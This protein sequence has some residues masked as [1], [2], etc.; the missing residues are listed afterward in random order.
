ML[1]VETV[2]RIRR[3]FH[4]KKKPIKAIARELGVSRNTIRKVLR[5]EET[6]FSYARDRQPMP[7]LARFRSELDALLAANAGKPAREKLTLIRIYEALKERGYEGGYDAV[8]RYG[9]NW[10]R[11]HST[12]LADAYV[13]LSFAPGEAFQFD[14][15]PRGRR[16]RRRH[17]C[18][19]GRPCPALPQPH[20]VRARL[21]ARDAGDGVRRA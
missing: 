7:R 12:S 18:G 1:A 21:P 3:D 6:A 17:H 19:E 20:A 14:W 11:A 4:V 9:R 16:A 5:S 10:V 8:R 2:A 13:P 15:R